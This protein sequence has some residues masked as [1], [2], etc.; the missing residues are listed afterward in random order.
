M[1]SRADKEAIVADIRSKIDGSRAMF[2]TNVIGISSNESNDLR[3]KVREASGAI[4][5][6][7]N[8]LIKK[9]AE[10]TKLEP[11]V[12]DLKGPNAVAFAFE[13]APGVAKALYET[14]KELEPVTL[15][16]GILGDKELTKEDVI[17][18]AKLPSRDQMLATL[19]AT[20]NA[21][22]GAFARV[23]NAIKDKKEEGGEAV[24]AAPAEEAAPAAEEPKTEE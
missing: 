4:V 5:C 9:A 12:K 24:A 11:F 16:A 21:P 1:L 13:D 8:T 2:L 15:T 17:A 3:Q 23:L 6:T 22:V 18:L 14:G 7:R 19:L 10:G 20:F